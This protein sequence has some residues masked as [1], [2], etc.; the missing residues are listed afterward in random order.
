MPH[1]SLVTFSGLRVVNPT[2]LELGL[3]MPGL[4]RRA[5]ALSELPAL[6]LIT[7]AGLNPEHWSCSYH[8]PSSCSDQLAETL[9]TEEPTLVAISALTPSIIEAYQLADILRNRNIPV[10]LGGLHVTSCPKEARQHAD[11]IVIGEGE[12]VWNSVLE[13]AEAGE[14]KPIYQSQNLYPLKQS[15]IPRYDLLGDRPRQRMTLQ[16]ERGCPFA[17]EFCGASR[18]LGRFRE[19]PTANIEAEL[20]ALT[21]YA[22]EPWLE[23]ADDN[24][25]AG[26]R[27]PQELFDLLESAGARYFTEAD[28]RIGE[29]PN[30]LNGLAQSG[31][32]QVLVGIESLQFR[33]SGMGTKQ[34]ELKRMLDATNAIQEAGVVVNA[35]L[36]VGADGETQSSIDRLTEFLI[37]AP[38]AEIQITLQTPFPGTALYRRLKSENRLLPERDWSYYNLFDVTYRPD[39]MTVEQLEAGFYQLLKNVFAPEVSNRRAELRKHIWKKNP[40]FQSC[41]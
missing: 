30:V 15:P 36:I 29:N 40:R 39:R 17:C 27:D 4:K 34:S 6:G 16:T 1:V 35:C 25:F 3:T 8:S 2:L 19:K 20:K 31:C 38:F 22:P 33:Y 5:G 37:E 23:L 10:V 18:L 32:V 24:T 12:P 14:L 41:P 13:D 21:T 26:N 7:L 11:A 28:W 9:I